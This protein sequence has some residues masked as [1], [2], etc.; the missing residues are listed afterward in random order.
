M[1]IDELKQEYVNAVYKTKALMIKEEPF[2][3]RSGGKSHIYL[4]H[5]II[6]PQYKY[7]KLIAKIYLKLLEGKVENYKLCAVDSLTSPLIA[8]AMSI[9]QGL[10]LV[11]VGVKRK[12]H[13][14]K[15][16]IFGDPSGEVV[17]IDDVSSTGNI[18]IDA[19]KKL[20]ESGATVR[21][22]IVSAYRDKAIIDRM[23]DEG[24]EL[25]NIASF[26]EIISLLKPNL[27]DK[28]RQIAQEE[29]GI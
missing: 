10:D 11:R 26:R 21:Y 17:I 18:I 27:T 7:L 16:F 20:R 12:E 6:M 2:D 14:T 9:I 24:I 22:A 23:K 13:G 1:E 19:A 28:E 5:R 8:S 3:L 15:E 25:L 4:N 29:F